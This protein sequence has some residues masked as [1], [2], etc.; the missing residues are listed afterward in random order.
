MSIPTAKYVP[1]L[2]PDRP[3]FLNKG[4]AAEA[5]RYIGGAFTWGDTAEGLDFWQAVTARLYQLSQGQLY[6][7]PPPVN[8]EDWRPANLSVGVSS[9]GYWLACF[10]STQM[11]NV[12]KIARRMAKQYGSE[13]GR[14]YVKAS[15]QEQ[16]AGCHF[17]RAYSNDTLNQHL[18]A[19]IG[20]IGNDQ[21]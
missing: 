3:M 17:V 5:A 19:I 4:H 15:K 2:G 18:P 21:V 8:P 1:S 11:H 7:P 12:D 20:E 10:A 16:A 6:T 13:G 9:V 14:Y